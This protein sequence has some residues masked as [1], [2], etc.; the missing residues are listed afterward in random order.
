VTTSPPARQAKVASH[1]DQASRV[2]L[3]TRMAVEGTGQAVRERYGPARRARWLTY[4][5]W[6]QPLSQQLP[7]S[8]R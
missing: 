2:R 4:G 5:Q 6:R 3:L 8:H 7:R 1:S